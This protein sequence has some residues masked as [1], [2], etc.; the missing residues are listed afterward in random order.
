MEHSKGQLCPGERDTDKPFPTTWIDFYKIKIKWRCFKLTTMSFIFPAGS[1][2]TCKTTLHL[3]TD[4]QWIIQTV[5][6]FFFCCIEVIFSF[7]TTSSPPSQWKLVFTHYAD[8]AIIEDGH[9][10]NLAIENLMENKKQMS[11]FF[12]VLVLGF[13]RNLRHQYKKPH[14]WK[15]LETEI[16][17]EHHGALTANRQQ[18][19][20]QSMNRYQKLGTNV[21]SARSNELVKTSIWD[22]IHASYN[23]ACLILYPCCNED[24]SIK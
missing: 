23:S 17:F 12:L 22:R 4:G 21:L 9:C 6:T 3:S 1:R 2:F 7:S 11:T 24:E 16:H 10:T 19:I 15:A 5:K 8:E 14:G 20:E 18:S 13:F